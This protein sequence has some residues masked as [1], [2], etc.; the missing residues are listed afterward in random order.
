MSALRRPGGLICGIDLARST[1]SQTSPKDSNL[2]RNNARATQST[3]LQS[4]SKMWFVA[5]MFQSINR[6]EC[7]P[8][9]KKLPT[10]IKSLSA[11]D[12]S[13][14]CQ[15]RMHIRWAITPASLIRTSSSSPA[16]VEVL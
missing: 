6:S 13:R 3:A 4:R 8:A 12:V 5:W 16:R 15:R 10:P 11:P 14:Q 2:S 1:S 9:L 7:V